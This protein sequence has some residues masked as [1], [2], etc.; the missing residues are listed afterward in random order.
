MYGCS[1]PR[2][3]WQA[4]VGLTRPARICGC[5]DHR[6]PLHVNLTAVAPRTA[7]ATMQN[8]PCCAPPCC[9]AQRP[10]CSMHTSS[11]CSNQDQP[12]AAALSHDC[13]CL[14]GKEKAPIACPPCTRLLT[15]PLNQRPA[16]NG[17][18]HRT[19]QP[20]KPAI[21]TPHGGNGVGHPVRGWGI[22]RRH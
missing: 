10:S 6:P 1:S 14:L 20:W 5:P 21:P 8:P 11:P 17:G 16:R 18:P 22:E 9:H 12:D 2:H 13:L 4:R 15:G 7:M 3:A 19:D